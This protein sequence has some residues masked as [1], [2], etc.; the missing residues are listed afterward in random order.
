MEIYRIAIRA[1]F[2]FIFLLALLRLTGKR[3]IAQGSVLDFV[4]A[5]ILGDLIDDAIWAE[6][7]MS[8]FII[9]ASSLISIHLVFGLARAQK[10]GLS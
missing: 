5:L 1:V 4:V 6:V 2:V 8:Q 9:A 3:S 7:P 10:Q